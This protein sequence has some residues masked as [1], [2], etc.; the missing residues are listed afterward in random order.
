M[1]IELIDLKTIPSGKKLYDIGMWFSTLCQSCVD[2]P[3]TVLETN[4]SYRWFSDISIFGRKYNQSIKQMNVNQLTT[5]KTQKSN[6]TYTS[7][8]LAFVRRILE[9]ENL[10]NVLLNTNQD[11]KDIEQIYDKIKQRLKTIAA[12]SA[13]EALKKVERAYRAICNEF[14]E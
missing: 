2:L 14:V 11:K 6:K 10:R 13:N 5:Y 12:P 7:D 9:E 4:K 1:T 3:T 8:E